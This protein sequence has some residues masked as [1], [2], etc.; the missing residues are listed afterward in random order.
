LIIEAAHLLDKNSKG[1]APV[2]VY[3][4]KST[5]R[6]SRKLANMKSPKAKNFSMKKSSVTRDCTCPTKRS[7]SR[8]KTQVKNCASVVASQSQTPLIN[9]VI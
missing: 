9:Q 7:K 1:P 4:K 3:N 6:N 5:E 8:Q 2:T